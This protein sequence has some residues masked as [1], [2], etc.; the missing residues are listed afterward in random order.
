MALIAYLVAIWEGFIFPIGTFR[1]S[2]AA[3]TISLTPYGLVL[4]SALYASFNSCYLLSSLIIS[5][6]MPR[7]L[8]GLTRSAHLRQHQAAFSHNA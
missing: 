7:G 2:R 3:C 8:I 1:T 6:E 4:S 5:Q